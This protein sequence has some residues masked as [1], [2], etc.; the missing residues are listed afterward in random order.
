MRI[1][2]L[3]ALATAFASLQTSAGEPQRLT[4]TFT[5]SDESIVDPRGKAERIT[6][7]RFYLTGK[8]AADIYRSMPGTAALD[9]CFDDGSRTKV[10][11]D[12]K[13]TKNAKGLHECW[14]G[15]DLRSAKLA[16]SFV[17]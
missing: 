8:S 3:I 12:L 14:F 11:G 2:S 7:V 10:R 6:H 16:P 13:C 5:L 4:G 1:T 17:C 9:Q 15:V